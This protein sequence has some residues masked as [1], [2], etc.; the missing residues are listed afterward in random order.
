MPRMLPPLSHRDGAHGWHSSG[1]TLATLTTQSKNQAGKPQVPLGNTQSDSSYRSEQPVLPGTEGLHLP[2]PRAACSST[3]WA[4]WA[5]RD[6]HNL[7]WKSLGMDEEASPYQSQCQDPELRSHWRTNGQDIKE[8]SCRAQ[9]M[10]EPHKH[11]TRDRS[12]TS[13]RSAP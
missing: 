13:I 5:G 3:Q 9:R 12:P 4:A 1:T 7:F 6:Q 8:G 10:K 11:W 2:P